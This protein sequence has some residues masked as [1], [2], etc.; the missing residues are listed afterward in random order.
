ME[1]KF[2]IPFTAVSEHHTP[3]KLTKGLFGFPTSCFAAA[4]QHFKSFSGSL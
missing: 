3:V 4:P 1:L 2:A